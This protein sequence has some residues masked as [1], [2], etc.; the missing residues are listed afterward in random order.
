MCT[1]PGPEQDYLWGVRTKLKQAGV[2]TVMRARPTH[3]VGRSQSRE[4][5]IFTRAVIWACLWTPARV[6]RDEGWVCPK[7]IPRTN[8][9]LCIF[10][11]HKITHFN[12]RSLNFSK[13]LCSWNQ[14]F[15]DLI[16]KTIC[17]MG[18]SLSFSNCRPWAGLL[19][20]LSSSVK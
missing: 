8:L 20:S 7:P 5:T 4:E 9:E 11:S 18:T 10:I 2:P 1:A 15:V 14:L 16:R 17:K 13:G 6:L 19:Y 12:N 3:N